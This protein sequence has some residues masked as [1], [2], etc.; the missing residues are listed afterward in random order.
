MS[1]APRLQPVY[2][3]VNRPLTIGGA[4]RHLFFVAVVLGGATFTFFGSLLAGLAMFLTLYLAARFVTQRDPQLLR[5][6]LRGAS[7]KRRYDPG[8]LAHLTVVREDVP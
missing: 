3:S 7:A 6:V 5:I 8:K 4:D 1:T 2:A